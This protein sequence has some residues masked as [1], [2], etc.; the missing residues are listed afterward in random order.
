MVTSGS[1]TE[2]P[3]AKAIRIDE[4]ENNSFKKSCDIFT[5]IPICT[6]NQGILPS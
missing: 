1:K 6:A 4:K 2:N 5:S 3:R